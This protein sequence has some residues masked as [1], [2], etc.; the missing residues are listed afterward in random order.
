MLQT[1][2][3]LQTDREVTGDRLMRKEKQELIETARQTEQII[4]IQPQT[5]NNRH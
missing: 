5:T 1:K 4:L 3:P 2:T